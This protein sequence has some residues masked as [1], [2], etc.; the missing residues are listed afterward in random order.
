M[1]PGSAGRAPSK[2]PHPGSA[3]GPPAQ[4][5]DTTA[6]RSRGYIPHF[7]R[8]GLVQMITFRLADALP[9]SKLNYMK[10]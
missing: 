1:Y 7:D 5:G 4:T 2:K 6:W 3:G 8:P 10:I 9:K